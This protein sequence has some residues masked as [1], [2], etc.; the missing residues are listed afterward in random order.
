[1]DITWHATYIRNISNKDAFCIQVVSMSIP[2]GFGRKF[3]I[4]SFGIA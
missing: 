2:L 1:M 3:L 4:E